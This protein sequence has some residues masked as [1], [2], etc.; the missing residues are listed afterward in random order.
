MSSLFGHLLLMLAIHSGKMYMP[1][2][3]SLW[4]IKASTIA[5]KLFGAGT[6]PVFIKEYIT[7]LFLLMLLWVYHTGQ[8]EK[9]S[10]G[11]LRLLLSATSVA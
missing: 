4:S 7:F 6:S 11:L 1:P 2:S 8:T 10:E 3:F 5:Y 9:F